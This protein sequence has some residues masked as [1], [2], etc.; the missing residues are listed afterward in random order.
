MQDAVGVDVERHLDLRRATRRR[1]NALEVEFAQQLVA[2][3]HLALALEHLDRH[4][5]LVVVG[6]REGLREAGRDGRVLGDHLG[7]HAA[8]RLDAQRQR[9]HV[10][11]QHVLA[12]AAEHL[13]LNGRAHGHRLVGVDVLAR[14]LAEEFL[15]L[16]LHLGH[17]GHAAHQDHVVDL[18]HADAGVLDGGAAGRNRALDELFDQRFQ[19][20]AGEL[21]VEVLRAGG[22]CRDV[23]QVDVGGGRT[24]QLDLGLLGG[25]LQALQR[26][27]VLGEVDALFLLEFADDEIDD[28]LVEVFAAQEGVAVGGQH[29]ELL[30]AIDIGDLDDR[31]VEGA[32][33]QVV[34]RDLAV[35]LFLLVKAERQ[36]RGG[37][38]VDDALDVQAG[39]AA[40]VLGGLALRVVEV[41]RHGDDGL[42]DRLA[43]VV[44]GG[45]LHLAQH[46]GRHLRRRVFLAAHLHPGVAVVG[47]GDGEGHQVDVLLHL[48]LGE[49]AADQAL[50][51]IQRVLRVGDRLALGRGTHQHLAVFLIR[52]DRRRGARALGVFDDLGAVAFHDG[53][54]RVGRAQ[55]DAND[56]AHEC[57]PDSVKCGCAGLVDKRCGF[58]AL[59]VDRLCA[60]R[61]QIL[62]SVPPR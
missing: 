24:R 15:D 10:E 1:W 33:A 57:S 32:A 20:G 21:D 11:Q 26:K 46:F 36:R 59:A 53:H 49:L 18:A 2:G 4:R 42:G 56:L 7:H 55:V 62:I 16:V 6:G 35:A 5:R 41:G 23:G 38:L 28:A 12:V 48:F 3:G 40:G 31:H 45:L 17:A 50:D 60:V 39:D 47:R 27:H 13:A 34:H 19:L 25:F 30:F 8:Q 54:A 37:G 9:R 58:Q 43:Q 44:L 14:L 29:L 22:I 51:R 61:G 52:H